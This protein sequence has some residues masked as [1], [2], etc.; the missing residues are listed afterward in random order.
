MASSRTRAPLASSR[1]TWA[2]ASASESVAQKSAA[3]CMALE[4][5][6]LPSYASSGRC[7]AFHCIGQTSSGL[8]H[9]RVTLSAVPPSSPVENFSLMPR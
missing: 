6:W 1:A 4:E 7:G 9:L 2:T 3:V 8:E 5:R